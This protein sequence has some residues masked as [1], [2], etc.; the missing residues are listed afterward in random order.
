LHRWEQFLFIARM[1]SK[2]TLSLGTALAAIALYCFVES[3]L[4]QD[5]FTLPVAESDNDDIDGDDIGG[6]TISPVG[7][8]QTRMA[9]L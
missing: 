8:A 3:S 1:Y 9:A 2:V 6:K 5:A 4:A 7:V